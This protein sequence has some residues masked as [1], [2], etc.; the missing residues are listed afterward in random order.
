MALTTFTPPRDNSSDKELYLFLRVLGNRL[1]CGTFT[2]DPPSCAANT[3]TDTT[4]TTTDAAV[5]TL[6]RAGMFVH[7]TPPS[8][9]N[10][11]LSVGGAWSATDKQLTIRI[12]NN[13]AAPINPASGTWNFFGV[14][15]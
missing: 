7:V 2:W 13:T 5:L 6:C 8:T 4:L 10:A 3:T 9:L 14:T 15:P 12:G 1:V 11:G